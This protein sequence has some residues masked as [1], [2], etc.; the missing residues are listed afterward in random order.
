[1]LGGPRIFGQCILPTD[2]FAT[3]AIPVR[4]ASKPHGGLSE[5]VILRFD[6]QLREAPGTPTN[7]PIF[8]G[9]VYANT[10]LMKLNVMLAAGYMVRDLQRAETGLI[11]ADYLRTI[12]RNTAIA[13]GEIDDSV[14]VLKHEY[15]ATTGLRLP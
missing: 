3:L 15:L 10:V 12:T 8:D 13:L 11:D 6:N 14:E 4:G 7:V 2:D 5:S 1:M 9:N